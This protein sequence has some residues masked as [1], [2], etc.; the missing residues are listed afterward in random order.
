[1]II[2]SAVMDKFEF[3]HLKVSDW[4]AEGLALA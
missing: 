1:M 3:T 4:A 2:V